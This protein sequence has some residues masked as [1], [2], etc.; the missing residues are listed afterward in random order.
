MGEAFSLTFTEKQLELLSLTKNFWNKPEIQLVK[1][2]A[3]CKDLIKKTSKALELHQIF[4]KNTKPFPAI[5]GIIINSREIQKDLDLIY[6]IV[7]EL[8]ETLKDLPKQISFDPNSLDSLTEIIRWS[9]ET[10]PGMIGF[11]RWKFPQEKLAVILEEAFLEVADAFDNSKDMSESLK[12]LQI[13]WT[14][15]SETENPVFFLNFIIAF[16]SSVKIL[17]LLLDLDDLTNEVS[18][19]CRDLEYVNYYV[20][21]RLEIG[22]TDITMFHNTARNI[23]LKFKEKPRFDLLVPPDVVEQYF[24]YLPDLLATKEEIA[25]IR[26]GELENYL[27]DKKNPHIHQNFWII[28]KKGWYRWILHK[29]SFF[30][31]VTNPKVFVLIKIGDRHSYNRLFKKIKLSDPGQV[32]RKIVLEWGP[33]WLKEIKQIMKDYYLSKRLTGGIVQDYL[34]K[35]KITINDLNP[36][37]KK[38]VNILVNPFLY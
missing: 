1:N 38:M 32:L 11:H 36:T 28:S 27:A 12:K 8:K 35:Y 4:S 5:N 18:Q 29:L 17:L 37:E 33:V 31:E 24:Y 3:H 10:R 15:I 13:K 6:Y 2:W 14:K 20:K 21:R 25:K 16:G 19:H 22:P 30:I 9:N 26:P 34:N 23:L 7:D